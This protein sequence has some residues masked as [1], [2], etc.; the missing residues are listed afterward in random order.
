ME[1]LLNLFVHPFISFGNFV[2]T[3]YERIIN[4]LAAL[5]T[6]TI[7]VVTAYIAYQQYILNK[8]NEKRELLDRRLTIFKSTMLFI[9][10]IAQND[11]AD[12]NSVADFVRGTADCFYLFDLEIQ[13]YIDDIYHKA[14]ELNKCHKKLEP[15]LP[16]SL[17]IGDERNQVANKACEIGHGLI[18]SY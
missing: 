1:T 17:P 14:I 5:L 7:A 18:I 12:T 4:L 13:K 6:P 2:L 9:I 11:R 16:S 15:S 10:T 3:N 8:N